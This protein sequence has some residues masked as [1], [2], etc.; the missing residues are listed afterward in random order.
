MNVDAF[1]GPQA[2]YVGNIPDP[3]RDLKV[4]GKGSMKQLAINT[5]ALLQYM[6]VL[7]SGCNTAAK[8]K[9]LCENFKNRENFAIQPLGNTFFLKH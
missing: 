2:N 3:K 7:S 5:G 4:G 1:L 8:K 9:G 6:D